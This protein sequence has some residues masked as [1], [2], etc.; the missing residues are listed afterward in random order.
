MRNRPSSHWRRARCLP[1]HLALCRVR[2]AALV[3]IGLAVRLGSTGPPPGRSTDALAGK[4]VEL[5]ALDLETAPLRGLDKR[6]KSPA[7]QI[8]PSMASE[9]SQLLLDRNPRG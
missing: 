4:Q 5:K 6:V 7:S 3:V 2:R 1:A 8:Q 9:S